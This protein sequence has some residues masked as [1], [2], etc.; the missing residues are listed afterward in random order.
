MTTTFTH[1]VIGAQG[2]I[3][4][5]LTKCLR[6]AGHHVYTPDRKDTAWRSYQL[7][8]VYYCAGLTADYAARPFDTIE[9]HVSLPSQILKEGNFDH[10][11]YLSSTRLYDQLPAGASQELVTLPLQPSNPR[12]LYDLSK[13]LGENLCLTICATRTAI[14][15]LSCVY[16]W[17]P[18]AT[19][20]LSEILHRAASEKSFV[21]DTCSGLVRDYIHLDDVVAGLQAMMLAGASGVYNLAS[22]KNVSNQELTQ[23]FN[24]YGWDIGVQRITPLQTATVCEVQRLVFLG[25]PP[26]SA[27]TVIGAYLSGLLL[28]RKALK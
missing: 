19:G 11:I 2:F 16:D 28:K 5:R 27:D 24:R 6:Q 15:R 22:G 4:S 18:G 1:T 7:G 10:L 17:N 21:L 20:Y 9:A 8:Q 12:H 14:A 13:A 26:R 3:G 23:I 25:A